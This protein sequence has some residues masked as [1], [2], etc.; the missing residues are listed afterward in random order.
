MVAIVFNLAIQR[1]FIVLL[2]ASNDYLIALMMGTIV[3]LITKYYLDKQYIF[4]DFDNS[5]RNNKNKFLL[6]S[7]NGVLTT[8]IFWSFESFFYFHFQ[9]HAF[10]EFGAIL[11]LSIGYFLKYRLDK[12]YVFNKTMESR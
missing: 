7:L 9:T 5:L 2:D 8:A 11:G 3:G 10:R 4:L 6:Y 1:L 12:K